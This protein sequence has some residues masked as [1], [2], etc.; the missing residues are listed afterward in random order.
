MS[1]NIIL[2]LLGPTNITFER[3]S[4]VSTYC[5]IGGPCNTQVKSIGLILDDI[6]RNETN[7]NRSITDQSLI[8]KLSAGLAIIMLVAGITSSVCSLLT[9][10]N[11]SLRRVG[12]GWY[13]LASSI[14][15]LLT[16]SMF[17]IKFWFV[18]LTQINTNV[19][20]S[21]LKGGCKL[22]ETLL[23]L[24][25]YWDAWLNACVAIERAV[26][27]YKGV[28]FNK[29]KSI[30]YAQWIIFI[31]PFSIMAT[32]IHEPLH[33]QVFTYRATEEKWTDKGFELSEKTE[34]DPTYWCT[35]SYS[36]SVQN[37]N[38]IILFIHLLGPF[39]ANFV[40]ALFVIIA[41]VRRRVRAQNIQTYKEHIHEQWKEHKQIVISP[42]ILLLLS[43]PRLVISLLSACLKVSDYVW[44]YLS[45]YF[46]S[47]LP[48]ILIFVVFVIPSTLYRN[49]FKESF[50][51]LCKRQ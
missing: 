10:R 42:I 12:C 19:H 35:T 32:I 27:V 14:T 21:I 34:A 15:S 28:S 5:H 51:K 40:S 13:L 50:L 9:F 33:R 24:F 47:F 44:L 4:D 26:N 1:S 36:Q 31:L 25:L 45:A 6:L 17:T 29:E 48:S 46:I 20:L 39:I 23:K 3:F 2:H 16:V 37:Y 11:V 18:I 49:T 22:I 41:S 7:R 38:T 30:R 43:T 8:I